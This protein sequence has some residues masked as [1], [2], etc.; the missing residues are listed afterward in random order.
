M[1]ARDELLTL[2]AR[3]EQSS[4]PDRG[5][6]ADI[7]L[8][9]GWQELPGDNWIGPEAQIVVPAYTSSIDTALTLVPENMGASVSRHGKRNDDCAAY[10]GK[11][12]S[13]ARGNFMTNTSTGEAKTM[14]LA[15]CAA[16]LKA[17]HKLLNPPTTKNR[18]KAAR[19]KAGAA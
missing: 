11:S 14:A 15:L 1:S 7:A 12:D 6:E 8:T 4:G 9:Q 17:R 10:V 3:C 19:A 18:K 2:A 5:L 13:D 16:A